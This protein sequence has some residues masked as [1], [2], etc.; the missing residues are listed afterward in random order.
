[1]SVSKESK[2]QAFEDGQKYEKGEGPL[3]D[4]PEPSVR[5][6]ES[7]EDSAERQDA[8]DAGRASVRNNK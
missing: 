2:Q 5:P 8:F 1:M 7:N 3:I 6:F 4:F